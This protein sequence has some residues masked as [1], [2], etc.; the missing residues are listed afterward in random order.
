MSENNPKISNEQH[1]PNHRITTVYYPQQISSYHST[2]SIITTTPMNSNYNSNSQ[3]NQNASQSKNETPIALKSTALPPNHK[4]YYSQ[5]LQK[6]NDIEMDHIQKSQIHKSIETELKSRTFF[7][8]DD[9]TDIHDYFDVQKVN[10]IQDILNE[11]NDYG[12]EFNDDIISP[13]MPFSRGMKIEGTYRREMKKRDFINSIETLNNENN[14]LHGEQN[15]QNSNAPIDDPFSKYKPKSPDDVNSLAAA[16]NEQQSSK[17]T[18]H[19]YAVHKPRPLTTATTYNPYMNDYVDSQDPH[20]IYH[21]VIAANNNLNRDVTP[22]AM[23]HFQKTTI[24]KQKPFSLMLDVYPMTDDEQKSTSIISAT[25]SSFHKRPYYPVNMNGINHNLQHVYYNQMKFPQLQQYRTPYEAATNNQNDAYF[26]KYN[27]NRMAPRQFYSTALVKQ[28]TFSPIDLVNMNAPS[29]I[30]VHLNLYPNRKKSQARNVEII[31]I[32]ET[33][34]NNNN[35]N[36]ETIKRFEN[37]FN[38]L[39]IQ[40]IQSYG[41]FYIPPFSAIQI[42]SLQPQFNLNATTDSSSAMNLDD[43]HVNNLPK[44]K[45]F[46]VKNAIT[47]SATIGPNSDNEFD[48]N[49]KTTNITETTSDMIRFPDQ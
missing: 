31:D 44:S 12:H 25:H 20:L 10:R 49:I 16:A 14:P 8:N 32:G 15:I 34:D 47:E 6:R 41:Q 45:P 30:T 7:P 23:S 19:F 35:P 48:E 36:I 11:E 28:S 22:K 2:Q 40:D 1:E 27:M 9:A 5:V 21:Q 37:N 46:K 26:R 4:Q 29:Q 42:N 17:F 3:S 38:D 13:S 39:N 33:I 18:T 43:E 24:K